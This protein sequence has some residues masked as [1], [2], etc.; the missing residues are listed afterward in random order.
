MKCKLGTIDNKTTDAKT[1][2]IFD[3]SSI[4]SA[5]GNV[6][7]I[8]SIYF[9][10]TSD[11]ASAA[12]VCT[13]QVVDAQGVSV[14]FKTHSA[15]AATTTYGTIENGNALMGLSKSVPMIKV[16]IPAL[17]TGKIITINYF[18]NYE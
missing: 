8:K 14:V 1:A 11:E 12:K 17:T 18:I 16:S 5:M 3:L 6:A 9:T 10:A 15:T 4:N 7:T 2:V 13:F